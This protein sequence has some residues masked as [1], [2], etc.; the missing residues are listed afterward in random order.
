VSV[1]LETDRVAISFGGVHAVRGV[2]MRIEVGE[3]RVIIGPNG[4][5]KTTFFNL[6]AG[7]LRPTAGRVL[8]FGEDVTRAG[9]SGGGSWCR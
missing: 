7:Q 3:R 6:I 8:L 2:T 1:A 5:G 4:A 9:Q